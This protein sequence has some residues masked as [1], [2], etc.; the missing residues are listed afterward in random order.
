VLETTT[1]PQ[2]RNAICPALG[3]ARKSPN[4]KLKISF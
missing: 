4:F 2:N 1:A 3:R